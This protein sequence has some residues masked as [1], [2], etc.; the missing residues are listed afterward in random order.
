M[1]DLRAQRKILA[2]AEY[3][4]YSPFHFPGSVAWQKSQAAL[5]ALLAFDAEHPEIIAEL[6]RK[7]LTIVHNKH[8]DM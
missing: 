7:K 1:M 4:A 6:M 5:D 8:V 3:A 2:D